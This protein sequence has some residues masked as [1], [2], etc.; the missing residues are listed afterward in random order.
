MPVLEDPA[1]YGYFR[2]EVGGLMVGL[3]EPVCAPWKVGGVPEDFSFGELPPDWDRMGPYLEKAM[4]RVPISERGRHPQVL[5]RPGELHAG[6]RAG[7]RRGARAA[8]TTSSRP[9]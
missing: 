4:R 2:E 3:F 8:R 1:H 7:R 6:S 9:G 5:L